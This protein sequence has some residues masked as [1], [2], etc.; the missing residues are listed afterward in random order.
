MTRSFKLEVISAPFVSG[1][2][3]FEELRLTTVDIGTEYV[4][5]INVS[6][7]LRACQILCSNPSDEN[8]QLT[9]SSLV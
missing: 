1:R 5:D 3:S 7:P 2:I 8:F 4:I 9:S 6:C